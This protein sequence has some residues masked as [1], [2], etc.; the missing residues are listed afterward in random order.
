MGDP[1][2]GILLNTTIFGHCRKHSNCS[3]NQTFTCACIACWMFPVGPI[4]FVDILNL[5]RY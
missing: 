5:V 2:M 3:L 1:V 4:L